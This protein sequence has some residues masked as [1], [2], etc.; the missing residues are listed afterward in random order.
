MI[1]HKT[2]SQNI[3][4]RQYV[5]PHFIGK[6]CIVSFLVK[7]GYASITPIIEVIDVVRAKNHVC[8]ILFKASL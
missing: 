3:R 6:V 4:K 2:V 7:D 5:L 1:R 8:A